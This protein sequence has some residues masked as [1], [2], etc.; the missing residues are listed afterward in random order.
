VLSGGD[1]WDASLKTEQTSAPANLSLNS[2]T[3]SWDATEGA[4]CYVILKDG[5]FVQQITTTSITASNGLYE[6][7]AV[8]EHGA[9]SAKSSLQ[10]Q[11][12]TTTIETNMNAS[13]F[14]RSTTIKN[15]LELLYPESVQSMAIYHLSGLKVLSINKP[16][17]YTNLETL[18]AG[19]YI[20]QLQVNAQIL[21]V[22]L[23]K[24]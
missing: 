8:S 3:L 16:M 20:V 9:L 10:V 22:K 2:N 21:N 11:G 23:L 7:M 4:V 18:S 1:S 19:C 15:E 6:I 24:L 13:S 5:V 12:L 14:L 17:Q